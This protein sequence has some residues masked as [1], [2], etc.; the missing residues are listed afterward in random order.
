MK[1]IRVALS[2]SGFLLPA[3]VGALHAIADAGYEVVEIAGTSGGSI[4]AALAASAMSLP[5]M[6]DMC[7]TLNWKPLMSLSMGSLMRLQAYCSGDRL[8]SF[9]HTITHQL[10]FHNLV[11]DL[12]IMASNIGNKQP[13]IFSRE[14]TPEMKIGTAARASAA[15]PFIYKPVIINEAILFDGG[16]VNN[17]PS[18]IL[19]RDDVLRVG[20]D[21]ISDQSILQTKHYSLLAAAPRFIDMLLASSED[22]HIGTGVAEGVKIIP[23][24]TGFASSLDR[25]MDLATRQRLFDVGYKTTAAALAAGV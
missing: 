25:R 10:T 1:P 22:A 3:H 4:V 15:I 14:T 19:T 5:D 21:L 20:I 24:N 18:D 8:L 11:I 17:M 12:K 2:G 23:V 9:L 16:V 13:Y 6:K 7:L